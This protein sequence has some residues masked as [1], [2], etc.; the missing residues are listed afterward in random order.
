MKALTFNVT[1]PRWLVLKALGRIRPSLHYRGA[2][3]AVKMAEI[4][5]PTLKKP[6]W[7]KVQT[8]LTG[9]CASDLNLIFL[10]D[11]PS[12]S[13]FTS[14]P[15]VLGHET[16]GRVVE[17][18]P[19]VK[20]LEVGDLVTAAPALSCVPRG[21]DPVCPACAAGMFAAC[22]NYALGDLAPGM[23]LGICRDVGGGFAPFFTAHNSQLFKLPE[24][25]APEVG[26]MIEPFSVALQ[27]VMNNRPQKGEKVLVIGGGV[28]GGLIVRALRALDIEAEITVS[29]PSPF[30]AEIC[31]AAG[32]DHLIQDGDLPAGTVRLTGAKRYKPLLGPDFV[33][34][35]FQRVYDT[36][37]SSKT[38]NAGLR[39]LA[40][41]G[42]LSQVGIG[43]DVKLDLTP[44]WLKMQTIKGVFGAG[45]QD[46]RGRP[47]HLFDIALELLAEGKLDLSGMVTHKFPLE[48][49][50]EMILI[51]MAK[52]RH[53]AIK[54]A[55]T[56]N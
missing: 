32:A 33:M 7:V 22:E 37:G 3:A 6:D 17:K 41:R 56:F 34:G 11:S 30:A 8:I 54:T 19:E 53:R 25:L 29:D 49:F 43:G 15:C 50:D 2:L 18:G 47:L 28:I 24:N 26:V 42:V 14:F 36:V 35:G 12:A 5:E 31:R 48:K 10:H 46:F 40:A 13:P 23:F 1:V 52:S 4:P 21:L 27:A 44:L 45:V 55:V 38:L 51:N 9:F 20:G 16:C 39:C